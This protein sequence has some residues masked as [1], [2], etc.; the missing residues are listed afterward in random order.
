VTEEFID[1]ARTER[2]TP[3]QERRL[4]VLKRRWPIA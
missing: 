1:L 3:G 2:R 4:D